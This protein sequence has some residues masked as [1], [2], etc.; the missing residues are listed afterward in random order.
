MNNPKVVANY[1]KTPNYAARMK[2]KSPP[3]SIL[4]DML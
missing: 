1:L 2:R 3:K 4:E